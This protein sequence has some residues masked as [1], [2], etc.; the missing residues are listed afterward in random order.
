MFSNKTNDYAFWLVVIYLQLHIGAQ[1]LLHGRGTGTSLR[2]RHW[3]WTTA[4]VNAI[5]HHG[6]LHP[7]LMQPQLNIQNIWVQQTKGVWLA[8]HNHYSC[9]LMN[10][11]VTTIMTTIHAIWM[12]MD[13]HQ[14]KILMRCW[15]LIDTRTSWRW[16]W[17]HWQQWKHNPPWQK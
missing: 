14:T 16:W 13:F 15:F 7:I 8:C 4:W 9:N 12:M 10:A 5:Y 6:A 1:W 3:K 2:P 11:Q 17:G